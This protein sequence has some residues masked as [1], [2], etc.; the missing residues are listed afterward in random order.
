MASYAYTESR[1][2]DDFGAGVDANGNPIVTPGNT[3]NRLY[4]VPRHGGSLWL[5]YRPSWGPARGL[6][7]GVGV[8]ARSERQGDNANDYQLPGFARW[9]ALAAY[10]W[11][12][13]DT[14]LNLQLNVDN[15]FNTR[16]FESLSGTS[17]V[18]PGWPRRWL[19]SLRVE[20]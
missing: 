5:A 6:K 18:M 13:G 12:A 10:G 2:I 1:I 8:V 19:V 7:L 3:G 17:S 14:Q 9:K 15:V 4:G 11:R 16:Y 20:L